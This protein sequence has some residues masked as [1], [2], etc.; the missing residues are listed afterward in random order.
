VSKSAQPGNTPRASATE[1]VA[2]TAAAWLAER[3]AGLTSAQEIEFALWR[4]ADPR[5]E[6]AAARLERTWTTLQSLRAFRPEVRRHPDRD[7]LAPA[8]RRR[9]RLLPFPGRVAISA[10]AACLALAAVGWIAVRDR[11]GSAEQ[12]YATAAGG[13]ERVTLADG[14]MVELN[15]TSEV[16]VM[17]F[18]AERRV[19]LVRGEAHFTVAKNKARPFVV[20]AGGVAVRAVGTAFNVRMSAHDVEVLVTEGKVQL[21]SGVTRVDPDAL[22]GDAPAD[23]VRLGQRA[24]ST[25]TLLSANERTVIATANAAAA[26]LVV[27]RISASAVREALAWQGAR[28]VF[29]DTPLADAV[30]QFNLRNAVQ[31]EL[32]GADLAALPIGGSFRAENVEGFVRLLVSGGDIETERPEPAK[33]VL[34]RKK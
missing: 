30:A 19:R 21:S 4:A 28:L 11:A 25:A 15:A 20:E 7:L 9:P 10:L 1:A 22:S 33:I 13:Y 12:R 6:A 16:S 18:P 5:H 3:D 27:E 2:A 31:L 24:R 29:A 8:I 34:R 17:F 32:A 26:K 14:S 23:A